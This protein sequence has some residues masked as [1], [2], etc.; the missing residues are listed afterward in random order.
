MRDNDIIL[1]P[2]HSS[3]DPTWTETWDCLAQRTSGRVF[4]IN[5]GGTFPYGTYMV[6][7]L[8]GVILDV[9]RPCPEVRLEPMW[10]TNALTTNWMPSSA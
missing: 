6:D 4:A 5:R 7:G 3:E 9:V 2:A 1:I 10:S 8:V